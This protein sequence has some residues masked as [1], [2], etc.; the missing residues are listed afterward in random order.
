MIVQRD[1]PS[2]KTR[3]PVPASRLTHYPYVSDAP[4]LLRESGPSTDC[5]RIDATFSSFDG[6]LIKPQR[7]RRKRGKIPV[8]DRPVATFW[9][10]NQACRGKGLGY[11]MG[12]PCSSDWGDSTRYRRDTMRKGVYAEHVDPTVR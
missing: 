3:P 2:R 1:Q 8:K 11:A 10:P 7:R 5:P 4:A 6:Q 9:R 12:Y